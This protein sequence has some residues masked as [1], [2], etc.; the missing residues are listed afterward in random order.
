MENISK[1]TFIDW[2]D[3]MIGLTENEKEELLKMDVRK[4]KFK[5]KMALTE[6]TE[7]ITGVGAI[8]Y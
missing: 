1:E 6:K 3:L 2:V 7:E 4:V 5:Y 8:Y